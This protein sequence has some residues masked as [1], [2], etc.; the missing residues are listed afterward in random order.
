MFDLAPEGRGDFQPN[1]DYTSGVRQMMRKEA[2]GQAMAKNTICLWY[3]KDAEAAARLDCNVLFLLWL[4]EDGAYTLSR[5]K[6]LSLD[7]GR[8][9]I[10]RGRAY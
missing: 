6:T 2:K 4:R 9:G 1:L 5:Q 7:C 10:S 3:D 8:S